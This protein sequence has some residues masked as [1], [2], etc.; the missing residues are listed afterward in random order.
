MF[1]SIIQTFQTEIKSSKKTYIKIISIHLNFLTKLALEQETEGH[2]L[3]EYGLLESLNNCKSN[4]LLE[5]FLL[6]LLGR[7]HSFHLLTSFRHILRNRKR[8]ILASLFSTARHEIPIMSHFGTHVPWL[9]GLCFLIIF[10]IKSL[11]IACKSF[12]EGTTRLEGF[13]SSLCNVFEQV[14]LQIKQSIT[15]LAS[16]RLS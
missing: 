1:K 8:G 3:V 9:F 6:G 13:L 2:G 12:F 10:V 16:F 4:S 7:L 15:L 11:L 5:D 14:F